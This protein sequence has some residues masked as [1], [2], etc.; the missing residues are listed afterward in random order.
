MARLY[1]I[2]MKKIDK[3]KVSTNLNLPINVC[4]V[5][6]EDAIYFGYIKNKKKQHKWLLK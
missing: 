5:L 2:S 4:S 6:V 3:F 1:I